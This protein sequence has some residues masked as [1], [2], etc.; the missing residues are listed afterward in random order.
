MVKRDTRVWEKL[1]KDLS[2]L[3]ESYSEAGFFEGQIHPSSGE[4]LV[5]IATLNNFGGEN[6]DPS[7]GDI[8]AR[9]FMTF[10]VQNSELV[11]GKR[12]AKGFESFIKDGN[13]H[14]ALDIP[15][16]DLQRW[17]GWT[18]EMDE[19]YTPNAKATV[20]KKG[21]DEPLSDSGYLAENVLRKVHVRRK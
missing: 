3:T 5:D 13:V 18:I 11:I 12:M 6:P 16:E 8:P 21:R 20:N 9:P 19:L 7:R 17:I 15:A 14:K 2:S 1:L 10:S 4:S